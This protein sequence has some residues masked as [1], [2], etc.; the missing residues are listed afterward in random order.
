MLTDKE[1]ADLETFKA[2][3]YKYMGVVEY[4][5]AKEKVKDNE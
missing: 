2:L 3:M 1:K 5:T 4:L